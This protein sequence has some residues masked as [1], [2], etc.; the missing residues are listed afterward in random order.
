MH[1]RGQEQERGADILKNQRSI[2]RDWEAAG[3]AEHGPSSGPDGRDDED[4]QGG[5]RKTS[6]N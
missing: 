3:A 1:L 5:R 4:M 2:R 6:V